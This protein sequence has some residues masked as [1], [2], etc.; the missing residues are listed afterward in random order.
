VPRLCL[1]LSSHYRVQKEKNRS[2]DLLIAGAGVAGLTLA[3]LAGRAGL[4]VMIFDK[5]PAPETLARTRSTGRTVALM[6]PSIDL[7]E[8]TG[9]W[10]RCVGQG[11]FL[12]T[13]R[14]IDDSRAGFLPS[15]QVSFDSREIGLESFGVNIPN[16]VL[17][18]ALWEIV[19]AQATVQTFFS[20]GLEGFSVTGHGVSV[21]LE[22]ERSVEAALLVGADG[23]ASAVRAGAGIE[24]RTHDYGQSA[25]TCL[26]AHDEPHNDTSTE[27]HRPSG[28]F[29]LVP[30]PG[31]RSSVV[32]VDARARAEEI[33]RLEPEA[34]AQALAHRTGGILG[35]LRVETPPELWPVRR[36]RARSLIAPRVALIAEAAHVMS[37]ITAQGL[38]LSLRDVGVLADTLAQAVRRG[39][40]PGARA[41][42][43]SYEARRMP[44]IRLRVAGTDAVNR[45]VSTGRLV[46]WLAR[47]AGYRMMEA[48]GP[49][50][51]AA[52]R[53]GLAPFDRVG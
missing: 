16:T 1:P 42:L 33:Q 4:S 15:A 25:I 52:I 36:L 37:P 47:R 27:F 40:D 13:M 30:L 22:G 48:C 38:N 34:F 24:T 41:V 6:R 53:Q 12:R 11:G 31:R 14:L 2:I 44:D 32:W 39:L 29:A 26:I 43:E 10:A 17:R 23:A 20:T 9:V 51:R 45:L 19:A 5:G 50:R 21:R 8:R 18:A 28:P 35:G 7:L 46:P 3:A 49:V